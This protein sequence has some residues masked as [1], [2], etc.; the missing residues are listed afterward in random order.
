MKKYLKV[1][2][3]VTQLVLLLTVVVLLL[4]VA[5]KLSMAFADQ[6]KSVTATEIS[7]PLLV[8]TS[9]PGIDLYPVVKIITIMSDGNVFADQTYKGRTESR[10]KL[11]KIDSKAMEKL[12]QIIKGLKQEELTVL[13][14]GDSK[15]QEKNYIT[16]EIMLPQEKKDS[17]QKEEKL[18]FYEINSCDELVLAGYTG[19]NEMASMQL[20]SLLDGF[21]AIAPHIPTYVGNTK[22]HNH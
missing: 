17:N 3:L 10:I 11:A 13:S 9:D 20:K 4:T 16:Y 12:R 6:R 5:S 19:K 8:K 2:L 18:K 1:N 22:L 15:C 14:S 21:S 7:H